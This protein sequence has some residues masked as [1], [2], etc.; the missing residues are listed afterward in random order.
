SSRRRRS[1]I[2]NGAPRAEEEGLRRQN[3]ATA[4][5]KVLR[6]L[7]YACTIARHRIV[8]RPMSQTSTARRSGG[9]D[10]DDARP[11]PEPVQIAEV[12]HGIGE[13]GDDCIWQLPSVQV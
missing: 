6:V 3:A 11:V 5:V 13:N 9:D 10:D 7:A 4:G 1:A 2:N 8:S 12:L